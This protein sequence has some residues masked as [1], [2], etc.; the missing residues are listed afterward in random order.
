MYLAGEHLVPTHNSTIITFGL[1][2]QNILN[3]PNVTIGIFSHSRPIAKSFLLQI[4]QEFESNK[5]LQAWFPDILYK[6]PARESPKWSEDGGISVIRTQNPK[7]QTIEAWGL[8]DGQPTSKHFRVLVYDDVVTKESV[9]TPEM[10]QKTTEALELSYNLGSYGGHRR[11][12]GTRYRY[13]DT[14]Q[15]IMTRG[16]VKTRVYP[17]TDDGTATG[18]PVLWDKET[19][20]E[21]RRDMGPYT[22]AAQCLIDPVADK[23]QGFKRDWLK[24]YKN[25]PSGSMN[26]YILVDPAH[27]KKKESDY[28]AMAVIGIGRDDNYYVLDMIRDRLNLTER[29]DRLIDL[30]MKW[31]PLAVGYERYGVQ[32]DIE[33]IRD[34]QER[35]NYR[36]EITELG[37]RL[38]KF[39]RIKGLIPLL[40]QGRFYLPETMNKADY[41]GR[42]V[43]LVSVFVEEEYMSFPVGVHDDMIDCMARILDEKLEVNAPTGS[44]QIRQIEVVS[45]DGWT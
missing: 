29:T 3:D 11:F 24:Y 15:T 30:H 21:K 36:F 1:T 7:E 32:A 23:A 37:G 33:H 20:V 17:C 8:V 35:K 4:K 41:E 40:E 28:T 38:A 6:N 12:I 25:A 9:T 44:E 10:I 22:F 5:K 14:Y 31:R 2:I 26:V 13:N 45:S 42:V 39:D 27:S 18:T 19:L 43:D 34:M 16:T